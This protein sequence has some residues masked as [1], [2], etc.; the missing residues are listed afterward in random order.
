MLREKYLCLGCMADLPETHF[1]E[2][3]HNS[4]ADKFNAAVAHHLPDGLEVPYQY[5]AALFF[6]NS[7]SGYRRIPQALKYKGSL[8]QGRFFA[9]M[10]GER[11]ASSCSFRDVDAVMPVPLHWTRRMR[12]GYNQAEV[13]AR[14]VSESLG[15]PLVTGTIYRRRRTRSQTTVDIGSKASNVSGAFGVRGGCLG[16]HHVLLVD[17]TFTTGATLSECCATLAAALPP[18][19]RIS[20]ATLAYVGH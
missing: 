7:E 5:A 20:V 16:F 13:I 10:L 4:M 15:A 11:L 6:Y 3:S 2:Y 14:K 18:G 8:G 17:D 19:A 1:W 9:A 12:R